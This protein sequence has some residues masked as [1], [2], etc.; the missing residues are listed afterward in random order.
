MREWLTDGFRFD[1]WANRLWLAALGLTPRPSDLISL[2][3]PGPWPD[4][5]TENPA[6]RARDVFVH[7]L[8]VQRIWLERC[9]LPTKLSGD[10]EQWMES[11]NDGWLAEIEA[12]SPEDRIAFR[13]FSGTPFER[14]FG[15]IARHV[16]DH[17]TYHRGQL[18]EIR[19]DATFPETGL[20]AYF[21]NPD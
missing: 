12:R 7:M 2:N 10:I 21:M 20:I 4:F 15:E 9:G 1:L 17:G 13:T 18:R 16:I 8:F 5:P 14:S 3:G 11:L 19:G 6:D